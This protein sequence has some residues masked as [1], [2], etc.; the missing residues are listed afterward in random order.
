[1]EVVTET[2]IFT[3]RV[4]NFFFKPLRCVFDLMMLSFADI[5]ELSVVDE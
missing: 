4:K 2:V 3:Y 1:M 5:I